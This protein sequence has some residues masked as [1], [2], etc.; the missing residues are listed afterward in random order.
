M[1]VLNKR[2]FQGMSKNIDYENP[3]IDDVDGVETGPEERAKVI[4]KDRIVGTWK[5]QE[6]GDS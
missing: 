1:C 4:C 5:I 3:P 6:R 2:V